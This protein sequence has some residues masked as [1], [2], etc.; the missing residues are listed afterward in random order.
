MKPYLVRK[1]YIALPD[2][3]EVVVECPNMTEDEFDSVIEL[4]KL[5][6]PGL[7]WKLKE[8]KESEVE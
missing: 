4:L 3:R 8:E 1:I 5:Q 2:I 6:K 7:T